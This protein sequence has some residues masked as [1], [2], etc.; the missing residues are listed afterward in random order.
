VVAALALALE[1]TL[2]A[3]V[4]VVELLLSFGSP[5]PLKQ[6]RI[7]LVPTTIRISFSYAPPITQKSLIIF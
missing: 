4:A 5:Q 7:A 6:K 3:A 2:A 1:L